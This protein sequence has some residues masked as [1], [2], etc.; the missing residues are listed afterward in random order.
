M[1]ACGSWCPSAQGHTIDKESYSNHPSCSDISRNY[2]FA[3]TAVDTR[4]LEGV[5]TL[6]I[7]LLIKMTVSKAGSTG[8]GTVTSQPSGINSDINCGLDDMLCL[9]HQRKSSN[10]D[11]PL[12]IQV[13]LSRAG[14]EAILGTGPL[15][16]DT[17][18][19]VTATFR[20]L[21]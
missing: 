19:S 18:K 21:L 15:T 5:P 8:T 16:M 10:P 13:T 17:E 7:S 2:Y 14:L 12:P 9:L 3:V 1:H 11:M 20:P 4:G 6:E